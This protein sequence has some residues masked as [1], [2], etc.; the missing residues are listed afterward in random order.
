MRPL[1]AMFFA[2]DGLGAGHLARTLAILRAL[3]RKLGRLEVLLATTSE[4]DA[5]LAAERIATVRWPTPATARACGW[6]DVARRELAGRVVRA[7][8]EALRPDLLVTDT[9]PSGPY[10][11]LS[12]LLREVPRRALV[13]RSVR[14]ERVEEPA[15]SQ[16]LCEYQLAIV[17]DDPTE[18]HTE[19]LPMPAVRVPPITLFEAHEAVDREAA[20]ARLGL[21]REG[22]LV[23]VGSGGGGDADAAAQAERVAEAIGRIPGGP[24]P[25][26]AVGPLGRR[27]QASGIRQVAE[28]PLQPLLAAFDGAIA[29]A[30]YNLAHELAKA[31]V[32][33]ALFAMPRSFDDQAGRAARFEAAGIGRVLSTV[34]D[35]GVADAVAW[36][37][38]APRPS[39]PAGGADRAAEALLS[40]VEKGAA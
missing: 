28:T 3:R 5:F 17:P 9:F 8:I 22:R 21:P 6:T 25:V 16:G 10:G 1:R 27:R 12:G 40:L 20:R 29:P 24:E 32:P 37:E 26:L 15:L 13:R 35:A 14:P 19:T 33:T 30:G 7:T 4:A 18:H 34:D 38:R 23:L 31:G 39:I 11:E 36:M 2:N